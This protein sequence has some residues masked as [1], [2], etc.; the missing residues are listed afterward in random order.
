MNTSVVI[1]VLVLLVLE[2]GFLCFV[3]WLCLYGE[4]LDSGTWPELSLVAFGIFS[5]PLR[6]CFSFDASA[7]Q[8]TMG[9]GNLDETAALFASTRSGQDI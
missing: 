2:V 5:Y 9:G 1:S 7:Q 3:L 8:A 4:G 6:D